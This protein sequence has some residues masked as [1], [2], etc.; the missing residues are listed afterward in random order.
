M[1]TGYFNLTSRYVSA[2]LSGCDARSS[3]HI[4]TAAPQANGFWNAYGISG[5][6]PL[7]YSEIERRF[8]NATAAAGRLHG[9][10]AGQPSGPGIALYEYW[11]PGWTFH[12]KG[13]WIH[14]RFALDG[15]CNN[16]D[17]SN[18]SSDN[19]AVITLVGSPNF[20]R[21]SSKRDLELQVEIRTSETRLMRRLM[22]ERDALFGR[23]APPPPLEV[24][25]GLKP[26]Q[27]AMAPPAIS[28]GIAASAANPLT[29]PSLTVNIKQRFEEEDAADDSAASPYAASPASTWPLPSPQAVEVRHG[30][31]GHG[32][33]QSGSS[34]HDS[35]TAAA[36]QRVASLFRPSA[37]ATALLERERASSTSRSINNAAGI[38][39]TNS[40]PEPPIA[41]APAGS[42]RGAPSYFDLAPQPSV[43]AA[44]DTSISGSTS[45]GADGLRRRG[46]PQPSS[47]SAAAA[48]GCPPSPVAAD[49]A[50]SSSLPS[51]APCVFPVGPH[52]GPDAD[53]WSQPDRMLSGWSWKQGVWIGVGWRALAPF[54]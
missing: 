21:R 14:R 15:N 5:A 7:A 36:R 30:P 27:A 45:G 38:A 33:Q 52:L 13:L 26:L 49:A 29:P 20:G 51:D 19:E 28:S 53:V 35:F 50:P 39:S 32:H 23:I 54:F 17:S 42:A 24:D 12:G 16:S 37:S 41:T 10:P 48:D 8:Y 47:S 6:I 44:G 31:S 11:R 2:L 18:S 46:P 34:S 40:S 22:V 1:A 9:D 4:L 3:I 25:D 43:A